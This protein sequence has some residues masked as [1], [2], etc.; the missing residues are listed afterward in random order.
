MS[1][2]ELTTTILSR[3]EASGLVDYDQRSALGLAYN[4]TKEH[5][6]FVPTAHEAYMK[7]DALANEIIQLLQDSPDDDHREALAEARQVINE[8]FKR[9]DF[10][11]TAKYKEW[12]RSR[13]ES[14]NGAEK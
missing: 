11:G 10:V 13:N 14:S 9:N 12:K 7:R 6:L 8:P 2:N 1:N 5:K 4:W 3:L